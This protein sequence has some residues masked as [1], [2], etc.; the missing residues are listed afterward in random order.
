MLQFDQINRQLHL[1]KFSGRKVVQME[2]KN[3]L[4]KTVTFSASFSLK[5]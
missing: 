1:S 5:Q 4:S 2:K 3:T